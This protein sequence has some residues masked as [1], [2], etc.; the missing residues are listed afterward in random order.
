MRSNDEP[1]THRTSFCKAGS[2]II[3]LESPLV[4][5]SSPTVMKSAL[6]HLSEVKST[7][8][9]LD[10]AITAIGWGLQRNAATTATTKAGLE[11]AIGLPSLAF[12]QETWITVLV[13]SPTCSLT[14]AHFWD[15]LMWRDSYGPVLKTR[16][17]AKQKRIKRENLALHKNERMNTNL[18]WRGRRNYSSIRQISICMGTINHVGWWHKKKRK[19]KF[20]AKIKQN[21]SQV[22]LDLLRKAIKKHA[23]LPPPPSHAHS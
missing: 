21:S 12:P 15:K 1:H 5:L 13:S 6:L 4:T 22:S 3:L 9:Q 2:R 11:F 14:Q 23:S 16:W 19:K 10:A 17:C 7:N 18:A 8:S 20:F